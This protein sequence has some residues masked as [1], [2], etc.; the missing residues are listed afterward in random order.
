MNNEESRLQ[1][2]C[3]TWFRLQYPKISKLLFSV[4]NGSLRDKVTG[5]IL[6]REGVVS[7]VSDLILLLPKHGFASLCIEMKAGKNKQSDNQKEW[8]SLAESAHNKYV[9]CRSIDEF[10]IIVNHYLSK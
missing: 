10:M 8:Q 2:A 3:I 7:G 1:Q 4:P 9:V 5:A 6:K